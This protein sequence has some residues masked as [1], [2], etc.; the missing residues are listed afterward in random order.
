MSPAYDGLSEEERKLKSGE[1]VMH[2]CGNATAPDSSLCR[3]CKRPN[4]SSYNRDDFDKLGIEQE[5]LDENKRLKKDNK[6]L[7]KK[8]K[9]LDEE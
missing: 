4:T 1:W 2:Y 7:K 6:N 8:L 9:E 5:L 3:V